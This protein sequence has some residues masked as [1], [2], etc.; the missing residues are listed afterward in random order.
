MSARMEDRDW[1]E[2]LLRQMI[3]AQPRR[4]TLVITV[5]LARAVTGVRP[6]VFE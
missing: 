3:D 5:V 6:G 4:N 2:R 1:C